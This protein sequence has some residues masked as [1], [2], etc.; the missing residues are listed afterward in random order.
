MEARI[1]LNQDKTQIEVVRDVADYEIVNGILVI[2]TKEGVVYG[3]KKF[4]S[5]TIIEK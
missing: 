1:A 4:I 5:F 3:F 2:R